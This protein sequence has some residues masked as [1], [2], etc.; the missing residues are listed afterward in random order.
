VSDVVSDVSKRIWDYVAGI[1]NLAIIF[2]DMTVEKDR[3]AA[4]FL[5]KYLPIYASRAGWSTYVLDSLDGYR[6]L[7]NTLTSKGVKLNKLLIGSHGDGKYLLMTG[8]EGVANA[9]FLYS[10]RKIITDETIVYFTACEGADQLRLLYDAALKT[11]TVVYAS[12]GL[13]YG[14]FGSEKGFYSCSPKQLSQ[15]DR[16]QYDDW[17]HAKK[18]KGGEGTYNELLIR[19]GYCKRVSSPPFWFV[20]PGAMGWIVKPI[21]NALGFKHE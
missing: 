3:I 19:G 9:N 17:H 12:T 13:N 8:N 2:P 7:V 14:G 1:K 5:D 21:A 16:K 20:V 11:Q 6:K 10:I 4:F 15:Q 18:A